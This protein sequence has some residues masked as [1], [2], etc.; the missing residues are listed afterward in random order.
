MGCDVHRV[1]GET[2]ITG[3]GRQ[4]I[5]TLDRI[6]NGKDSTIGV[7]RMEGF[8]CFICEDE[9]RVIKVPGETRIPAGTY[10]IKLRTE[11]NLSKKYASLYQDHKGM[12]WLQDV[13]GFQWIYIHTGNTDDH[14]EGCL[15][16]GYGCDLDATQ[17]GGYV[18]RSVEAYKKLYSLVAPKILAGERVQIV[19][20]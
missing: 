1:P 13:I 10:D 4:M 8:A 16:T 7:L 11:G 6:F 12:L 19:I 17:G 15:L 20:Q 14:T 2:S 9:H 18:N 3:G 5:I